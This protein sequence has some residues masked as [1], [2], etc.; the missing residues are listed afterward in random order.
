MTSR[1]WTCVPIRRCT[2]RGVE[3]NCGHARQL[4]D[5]RWKKNTLIL[6]RAWMTYT[7]TARHSLES[8]RA[9]RALLA[10]NAG[11]AEN[12][13][14]HT[15]QRAEAKPEPSFFS[16]FPPL[17]FFVAKTRGPQTRLG[18]GVKACS[19]SPPFAIRD[20]PPSTFIR[21]YI[22]SKNLSVATSW[23]PSPSREKKI[24]KKKCQGPTT[25]I[26]EPLLGSRTSL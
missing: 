5:C 22:V 1:G 23:T 8:C 9:P 17:F 7:V 3:N 25:V 6:V 20:S 2:S 16:V 15:V 14:E 18:T 26:P 24:T 13:R 10:A 12:R 21:K 11:D 19:L 4:D